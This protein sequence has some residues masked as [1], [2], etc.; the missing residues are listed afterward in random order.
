MKIK[1]FNENSIQTFL[2]EEKHIVISVQDPSYDFVKLPEQESRLNFLGLYFYDL[3]EDTGIFPYSRFVFT[4]NHAK[5]ILNFI[6]TWKDKV[7]LICINCVVG[8]SRSVGIAGALSKILNGDDT[9]YFKHYCPNMLVYR[10]ILT[11]RYGKTFNDFNER[12]IIDNK[13]INFL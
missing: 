2:T 6:D 1:V 11:E 10:T 4:Q 12:P 13:D 9:Y 7:D 8:R 5:I 3:D